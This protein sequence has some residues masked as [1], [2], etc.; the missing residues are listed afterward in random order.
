M[1]RRETPETS[2]DREGNPFTDPKR[3]AKA[4]QDICG[5]YRA[6]FAGMTSDW[7]Y[8]FE[9]FHLPWNYTADCVCHLCGADSSQGPNTFSNFAMNAP[10]FMIEH[11][12]I[13]YVNSMCGI[14]SPYTLLPGWSLPALFPECMHCGCLGVH[15]L[16]AGSALKE[17]ANSGHWGRQR[18]ITTWKE[19]LAVQ[20]ETAFHEFKAWCSDKRVPSRVK[21]FTPNK[22]SLKNK[23]DKPE[24]K[25]K[26]HCALTIVEWLADVCSKQAENMPGN[27]CVGTRAGS[28]WSWAEM[29]RITRSSAKRGGSF[30]PTERDDLQHLRDMFFRSYHKMRG[31]SEEAGASCWAIT[32]KFH[33]LDH[34]IRM[35]LEWNMSAATCWTFTE[36]DELGLMLRITK[37][38][39]ALIV[40]CSGF[41]MWLTQFFKSKCWMG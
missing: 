26:D 11:D 29:F 12:E 9:C 18:D 15:L 30:T 25:T 13:A 27:E 34:A 41:H 35:G 22:L 4:G 38:L 1:F 6:V 37:G 2:V 31:M 14:M 28:L 21:R 33:M 36:E 23:R 20:L 8:T 24:L 3:A 5:G 7:K 19:R 32:P 39:H 17:L 10:C 16:A 40:D